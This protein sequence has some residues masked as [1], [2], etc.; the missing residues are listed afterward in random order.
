MKI[1]HYYP[2][3]RAPCSIP[4]SKIVISLAQLRRRPNE[5]QVF[6]MISE[7]SVND[8]VSSSHR[9]IFKKVDDVKLFAIPHF[10]RNLS[11]T[12]CPDNL[13][14]FRHDVIVKLLNDGNLFTDDG[15]VAELFDVDFCFENFFDPT[16]S[17]NFYLSVLGRMLQNFSSC[18][19]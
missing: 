12:I 14:F 9:L 7:K 15:V 3:Q 11:T 8:D 16:V 18:N 1:R 19:S 10:G 2:L 4:P 5:P 13:G 6:D 17:D